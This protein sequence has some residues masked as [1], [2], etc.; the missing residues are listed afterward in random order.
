MLKNFH[1]TAHI[2]DISIVLA[3]RNYSSTLLTPDFLNGSGVIPTDWELARPP[4][5]SPRGTHIIFKNG[6]RMSAQSEM[7]SFSQGI[8]NHL[9]EI[10]IADI[11]RRYTAVLPNLDYRAVGLNPQR[12][13][14][15]E[16]QP[17]AAYEYITETILAQGSWQNFGTAPMRVGI[18]LIYTLESRQLRLGINEVKLK[19]LEEEV[20]AVLFAGNF[21]HEVGGELGVERLENLNQAIAYWQQDLAAYEELIDSQFLAQTTGNAISVFPALAL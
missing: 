2:Q 17:D 16:G 14:T 6:I 20:P 19:M 21:H 8:S 5:I 3:I 11:A 9:D 7:V 4:V 13:V 15:F 10:Q 12:F 1:E 18:N